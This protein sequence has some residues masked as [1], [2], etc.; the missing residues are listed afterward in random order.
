AAHDCRLRI[1]GGGSEEQSARRLASELG[2]ADRVEFLGAVDF[3][4]VQREMAVA[5]VF[6]QHSVTAEHDETE[7]LPVAICEAMSYGLPVVSTFH[8]GIPEIVNDHVTGFLTAE[9]DVDAMANAMRSLAQD[10]AR[11]LDFGDHGRAAILQG[12]S[13]E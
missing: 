7:G 10:T 5:D 1:I 6:L 9:H 8:A 11:R 12:F 13:M 4:V 3:S 2:V